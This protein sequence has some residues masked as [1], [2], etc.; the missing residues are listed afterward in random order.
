M[1]HKNKLLFLFLLLALKS[2]GQCT[3]YGTIVISEIYF[4]T[5]YNEYIKSKYHSFGEYIELFN[6]SDQA[7]DLNGWTIKDN[8]T[9]YKITAADDNQTVIQPGGFKIITYDGF[10][11]GYGHSSGIGGRQK[12]KELFGFPSDYPDADI[13]LQDRMILYN[14][15]D[16]VRVY[17]SQ[18]VLVDEVSYLNESTNKP[19]PKNFLKIQDFNLIINPKLDNDSGGFFNGP[20]GLVSIYISFPFPGHWEEI[21]TDQYST[22]IYR[23]QA[24]DFYSDGISNFQ[25]AAATPFALPQG[26]NIPLK[27]LDPFLNY[28]PLNSNALNYT[29][30]YIYDIKTGNEIGHTRNYFNDKGNISGSIT[31]DYKNALFWGTETVYDSFGRKVRESFPS[32]SCFG[33]DKVNFISSPI[34]KSNFLDKYYGNNNIYEEYQATAEQAYYEV[35]YDKLNP[36]NTI[37]TVGGNQINGDWKTG[38]TFTVPVAQEMYYV[39]GKDYYDGPIDSNGE[40]VITKFYKTV[41]VDPNGI[42]NVVFSDGEKKT[43]AVA[44]S[45]GPVS[46]PV[47]S[48]IGSQGYIDIHIPA[49]TS[50]GTFLGNS[51]DY[52]IYN[53]K[54]GDLMPGI[55]SLPP[56]NA[57]RVLANTPPLT[58]P[59]AYITASGTVAAS[60]NALGV[61]YNVNYYDYS[62]NI[63]NKTGQLLKNIQPNGFTLHNPIVGQPGYMSS[64][65]TNFISSYTYDSLGKITQMT[66]PD[67]GTGRTAYRQDG[68]VR[69]SQS[70]IQYDTR[71]SY[72]NYDEFARPIESGQITG[73]AGIWSLAV[74]AVDNLALIAGTKTDQLFTV[75]DFTDNN[76]SNSLP[77][78]A[79]YSLQILAPA[80][81][82]HNLSNNVAV[83]YKSDNGTTINTITWYSYNIYGRNEWV[84]QYIQGIGVKTIDYEYDY[85]GN[86]SKIIYQ[87]NNVNERFTHRYTYDIDNSIKMVETSTSNNP[88]SIDAE[89]T[90]YKSGELKRVNVAQGAQGLDYVYTLGGALKSINHPSLSQAKD[91]GHDANDFFGITLDYYDGDYKRLNNQG[92]NNFQ[93]DAATGNDYV[94]NIKATRWANNTLDV[95]GGN[96]N[97]KAYQY[98]YNRNNWLKDAYFRNSSATG[99]ITPITPNQNTNFEGDLQYDANGNI[100]SLKRANKF[101]NIIDNLSYSYGNSNQLSAV[102]DGISNPA[103]PADFNP[104]LYGT[105]SY[106]Y[107]SIGQLTHDSEQNL[108][109]IYNT[110]GLVTEVRRN[111][112]PLVKFYYN[113]RGQRVRKESFSPSGNE[114]Y[115]TDLSGNV[116]SVYAQSGVSPLQQREMAIYGKNRVGICFKGVGVAP[117]VRN[118]EITDHLGNVRAVVQKQAGSPFAAMISYNDYYP[119]GE[120]I[121]GRSL[122]SSN[123]YR[124]AYQGQE[125]DRETGKEAFKL[126]L[127]DG[128]IGRWLSPDP[129]GQYSS[130]YLG[131]GNNPLSLADPDGG[132]A[133]PPNDYFIDSKNNTMIEVE[134]ADNFDRFFIDG[135]FAAKMDKQNSAMFASLFT[136]NSVFSGFNNTKS[137]QIPYVKFNNKTIGIFTFYLDEIKGLVTSGGARNY[138]MEAQG[139]YLSLDKSYKFFTWFQT[140]DSNDKRGTYPRIDADPSTYP[141]YKK[142]K[143]KGYDIAFYDKP[144]QPMP[145]GMNEVQW[146]AELSLLANHNGSQVVI[147]TYNYGYDIEHSMMIPIK[148]GISQPSNFHLNSIPK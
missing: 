23:Y 132:S 137:A 147:F 88:F 122:I 67:Q 29:D 38:Y 35:N 79:A 124:Y 104:L 84:V 94:G 96:T 105:L 98:S 39:Y 13:I 14:D 47:L 16:I 123:Y 82:Q 91:P 75:Y 66:T 65:A 108:D 78:P 15:T 64:T 41:T 37:N 49:G 101:G 71:V 21:M 145:S 58:N 25:T 53:L 85:K 89:Y 72:T 4:D 134:T 99:S 95:S 56:G 5:R 107:N 44:R 32:V 22:A 102:I 136:L 48:L 100:T 57:Y 111:S 128:R 141:Y 19:N 118:Y 45:G 138:K 131:M 110:S 9:E 24:S 28:V 55:T 125:L 114:Y 70:Q 12:F 42:E 17:T 139:A 92:V 7:I 50:N 52:T 113:E 77:I 97:P 109:Y 143:A 59:V 20:I 112:N 80:Y 6:S 126:R 1:G 3:N 103:N 74:A 31:Q 121:D 87:K 73:S 115:V 34:I 117:D 46:Y 116:V 135:E 142:E 81:I 119:F 133:A 90:Y 62:V 120:Q 148:N 11:A 140:I 144:G 129:K 63:Y 36:A 146:R 2:H 40:E 27:A 76:A 127:W 60:N 10:Y 106:T 61:N 26:M 33:M 51:S 18:N 86:V 43:L 54:T 8:H 69:Y 130:P 68:Q 93:T 30:S 83:T